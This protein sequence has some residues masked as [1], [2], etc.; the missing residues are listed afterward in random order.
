MKKFIAL[1]LAGA[2]ALSLFSGCASE[3]E[4][5]YVPTGKALLMEGDDPAEH[6][7]E[8]PEPQVFSLAYSKDKSMNPLIGYSQTNRVLF[9]LMYQGLFAVDANGNPTPIL[10]GAYQV[11]PSNMT[12]TFYLEESATFSDGSPVT[13]EDVIAS[14][15]RARNS[16]YYKGRFTYIDRVVP[17][18]D[19]GIDFMLTTPYQNLPQLLD[20]PIVK[21]SDVDA[22]YPIGSGPYVLSQDLGGMSL[23]RD[24]DWWGREHK[25]PV[26]ADTISLVETESDAQVRDEFEFSDVALACVNP[27]SDTYAQFRCDFEL[28][29]VDSGIM[30]YL[31]CNVLYSDYFDDGFLRTVL[32]YAIDRAT[33]NEKYYRGH[34]MEATL[35]ISPNSPHYSNTLAQSYAY[36]SLKFI[37]AISSWQIPKDPDNPDRKIKLLVNCDDSARVR[38]ARYLAATLTEFG[39]PTGTLEYGAAT[40]PTYEEVLRANN[41]DLHLGQTRLPSNYDLSEFFRLWGNLS[42]GG[43]P[44]EDILKKCKECLANS[45]NYYNLM[46]LLAEDGRIIPILFGNY[47]VFSER[48][49]F[50]GLAPARDNA[51]Y[52]TMGKTMSGIKIDTVYN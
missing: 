46:Q 5:A 21:A 45:G 47:Y 42:W 14:M 50:D 43:L 6:L 24:L 51:F 34:G 41:W 28:W 27:L 30:L 15:D 17:S 33:I 2:M 16:D 9:S 40:K 19:G 3:E 48:G 10:C 7:A 52:Y 20:I 35:C 1:V 49:L 12:Y 4:E 29:E 8:E 44:H 38:T 23:R 11:T 18:S 32:T 39:I 22:E 25:I 31:G 13:V 26:R 37:D 36:D